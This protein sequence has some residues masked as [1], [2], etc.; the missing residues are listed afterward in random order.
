MSI[1]QDDI[2][3]LLDLLM[4]AIATSCYITTIGVLDLILEPK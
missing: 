4:Y 1:L 3:C 2:V